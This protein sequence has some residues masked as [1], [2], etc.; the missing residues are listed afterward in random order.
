MYIS[1][2]IIPVQL[3]SQ[4]CNIA[5]A[6]SSNSATTI[7][8]TAAVCW[9]DYSNGN[10]VQQLC[11]NLQYQRRKVHRLKDIS[12]KER[13][14]RLLLCQFRIHAKKRV[15]Q[16]NL[17]FKRSNLQQAMGV[18]SL[19]SHELPNLDYIVLLLL[20][21]TQRRKLARKGKSVKPSV[22]SSIVVH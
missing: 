13:H 6:L 10:R 21:S 9:V 18:V 14:R 22:R 19:L 11:C 12:L 15:L 5:H 4:Q 7:A 3:Q 20:L 8:I 1:T 17:Q 16:C 2:L